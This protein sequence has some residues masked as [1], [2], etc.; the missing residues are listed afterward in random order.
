MH[1]LLLQLK[2]NA[3]SVLCTLGGGVNVYVGIILS[4]VT[5]SELAPMTLFA[6][7]AQLG[8]LVAAQGA[9]QYEIALAKIL[10]DKNMQIFTDYQRIHQALI[11]QLL[12]VIGTKHHFPKE[13]CHRIGPSRHPHPN[14]EY[15]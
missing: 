6:I 2:S 11:H 8:I 14:S 9:T 15:F 13:P 10:H 12:G 1:T 5:Y 3:I 4:P 7:P